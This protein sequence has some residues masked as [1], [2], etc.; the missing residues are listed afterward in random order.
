VNDVRP[1]RRRGLLWALVALVAGSCSLLPQAKGPGALYLL[2]PSPP[3]GPGAAPVRAAATAD[4][5]PTLLVGLP[6]ARAGLDTP[7]MIYVTRPY[8][9]SYYASSQW[10]DTP[11]HMLAPALTQALAGTGAFRAVVQLPSAA[12]GDLRLEIE[13]LAVVQEFLAR[14]SRVRLSFR[15]VLVDLRERTVLATRFFDAAEPAPTDNAYGGVVAAN[16]AAARLLAEL[17]EWVVTRAARPAAA[18]GLVGSRPP[19]RR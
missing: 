4:P 8:A 14:P 6:Q 11:A 15:A 2:S 17:N 16:R 18:P 7:R 9:L 3:G 1:T 10:V 19:L 13:A 12:A 5:A